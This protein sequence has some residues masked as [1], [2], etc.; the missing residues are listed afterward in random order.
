MQSNYYYNRS[1]QIPPPPLPPP[2]APN[3]IP[4]QQPQLIAYPQNEMEKKAGKKFNKIVILTIVFLALSH[5]YKLFDHMYYMFTQK[6]FE[7]FNAETFTPTVK[8]YIIVTVL[9][10]IVTSYIIHSL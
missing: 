5:S 7:I 2:I 3:R 1:S 9:F 10:F 8:G 4:V 6:Q